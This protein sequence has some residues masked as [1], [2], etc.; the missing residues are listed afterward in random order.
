MPNVYK[1]PQ[2]IDFTFETER[3][4]IRPLAEQDRE[5]FV[6][7]HTDEKIMKHNGG[8]VVPL[9][10]NKK[11]NSAINLNNKNTLEFNTL[12]IVDKFSHC[13]LGIMMI[14][15][16][17][18]LYLKK[19]TET[20]IVLTRLAQGKKIPEEAISGLLSYTF[21]TLDIAR[22]IARFNKTNLATKKF[23]QKLGFS[24]DKSQ[25]STNAFMIYY[26]NK[27]WLKKQLNARTCKLFE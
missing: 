3:L 6:G 22:I 10:A 23:I 2:G 11:F 24:F 25:E 15:Q 27:Q 8:V 14:F 12:A 13:T 19:Q 4:L 17:P 16:P 9:L 20:G 18:E 26:D 21:K 1:L 5:F 7:L